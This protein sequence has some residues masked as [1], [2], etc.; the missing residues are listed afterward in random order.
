M[1]YIMKKRPVKDRDG[2]RVGPAEF[3]AMAVIVLAML[4][5][6]RY[7]FIIYRRSAGFVLGQYI[8]A[9]N[10][11][12]L[13]AQ[14]TLLDDADKK[15]FFP[16]QRDYENNAPQAQGYSS[17]ITDV[18]ISE[19]KPDPTK[20]AFAIVNAVVSIRGLSSGKALYQASDVK[21]YTDRYL[22]HKSEKGEWKLI[23]SQ[24]AQ[25]ILKAPPNPKGMPF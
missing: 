16:T 25:E 18:N 8:N 9:I 15:A 24:S 3:L 6:V 13:S 12:D 20:P 1:A 7:Y 21:N 17:R 4:A 22:L 2:M 19:E 23:L 11:G 10:S 14:Y 5:G